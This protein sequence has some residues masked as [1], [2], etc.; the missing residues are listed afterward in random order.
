MVGGGGVNSTILVKEII[1]CITPDLA[2]VPLTSICFQIISSC[3]RP[4]YV[5]L[6]KTLIISPKMQLISK[7]KTGDDNYRF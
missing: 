6:S 3:I 1:K 5:G 2:A 4:V 7:F